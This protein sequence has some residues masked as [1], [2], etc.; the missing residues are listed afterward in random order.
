MRTSFLIV[1]ALAIGHGGANGANCGQT[2]SAIY[3]ENLTTPLQLG[4]ENL[5]RHRRALTEEMKTLVGQNN[6]AH[7]ES[8][9]AWVDHVLTY[10][11]A[12]EENMDRMTL[13]IHIRDTMIDKRDRMTVEKH[14]AIQAANLAQI[15]ETAERVLT[16]VLSKVS[17]RGIAFDV[18]HVRDSLAAIGKALGGCRR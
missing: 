3:I 6:F 11:G 9:Y 16:D 12:A 15:S 17:R 14:V 10:S 13:L 7:V 5:T 2:V 18:A 4:R 1:A 8:E